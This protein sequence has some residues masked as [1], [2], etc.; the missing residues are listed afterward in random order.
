MTASKKEKE[1]A[2]V[3]EGVILD[4]PDIRVGILRIYRFLFNIKSSICV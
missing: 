4:H 3:E 2:N 1:H